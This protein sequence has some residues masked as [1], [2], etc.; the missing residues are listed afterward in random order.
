MAGCQRR[1]RKDEA[2]RIRNKGIER[3]IRSRLAIPR[4]RRLLRNTGRLT[5]PFIHNHERAE[6]MEIIGISWAIE[7]KSQVA[8]IRTTADIGNMNLPCGAVFRYVRE[9]APIAVACCGEELFRNVLTLN[10]HIEGVAEHRGARGL[11]PVPWGCSLVHDL[12]PQTCCR[13]LVLSVGMS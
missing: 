7:I 10:S 6:T 4:G 11:E 2:C 12:V 5:H 9:D 8:N 1:L 3:A 13:I